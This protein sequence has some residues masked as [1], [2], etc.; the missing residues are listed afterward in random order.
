MDIDRFREAE[1]ENR[2]ADLENV[3]AGRELDIVILRAE[4]IVNEIEMRCRITELEAEL[5]ETIRS[6]QKQNKVCE[7]YEEENEKLR[8]AG[9]HF[10]KAEQSIS[11]AYMRLRAKLNAWDAPDI[12]TQEAMYAYVELCLDQVLAKVKLP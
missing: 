2:I 5:D 1:M 3:L 6:H 7:E 10:Q 8:E 9:V 4:Q 12:S 11:S